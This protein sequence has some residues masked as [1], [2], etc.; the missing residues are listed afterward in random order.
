MNPAAFYNDLENRLRAAAPTAGLDA[1]YLEAFLQRN[2]RQ[3]RAILLPYGG[4]AA[5]HRAQAGWGL[6]T[7]LFAKAGPVR[8]ATEAGVSGLLLD[9]TTSSIPENIITLNIR[10]GLFC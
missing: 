5:A 2:G 10:M 4:G 8:A 1:A 6:S 7:Q 9:L 3:L